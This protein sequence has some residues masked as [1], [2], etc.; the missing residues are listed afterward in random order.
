VIDVLLVCGSRRWKDAVRI[1]DWLYSWAEGR[2]HAVVIHG[3]ARGADH[4]AAEGCRALGIHAARV[5][6]LWDFH[7]KGAGPLRNAIMAKMVAAMGGTAMAFW[8]GSSPG[9]GHMIRMCREHG[10]PVTVVK[11]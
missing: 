9:T 8:D 2:R 4:H 11:P 1:E 6:A 10:V 3:G 7:G 5:D